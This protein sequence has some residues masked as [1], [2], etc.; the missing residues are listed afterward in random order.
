M[1]LGLRLT[2]VLLFILATRLKAQPC[3]EPDSAAGW[4]KVLFDWKRETGVRWTHD[5]LRLEL[6]AIARSDQE[7]RATFGERWS[8]T[9]YVRRLVR[10]DSLR[11]VALERILDRYGIPTRNMV[12]ARGADAAML[13]GQHSAWLQPRM[14]RMAKAAP[15]GQ[16][17][18]EALA[19]MEDRVLV[20]QGKPQI[21][22]SQF[23]ATDA[24]LFKFH[25]VEDPAGMEARR[26]RVGLPPL[27][28]YI[29]HMEQ[30]GMK[31]DRS[32]LPPP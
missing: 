2:V 19:L 32:T 9:A 30:A 29:C 18:P 25:P 16:I 3:A 24:G 4:G 1:R 14:L 21:Y 31:I 6:I 27:R 13:I 11:S 23:N 12:G 7:D 22:G 28:D 20:A 8:D 15:A 5:S 10:G 17:S 26:A